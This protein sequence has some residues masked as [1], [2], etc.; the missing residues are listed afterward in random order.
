MRPGYLQPS[1]PVVEPV[2]PDELDGWVR[3][4]S[5]YQCGAESCAAE[6]EQSRVLR[7]GCAVGHEQFADVL[8]SRQVAD[9]QCL[10]PLRLA[11]GEQHVA[12]VF[13]AAEGGHVD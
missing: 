3:C 6:Q 4:R 9:G 5:L 2:K 11:D 1:R 10:L 13:T 12:V 7:A 8:E